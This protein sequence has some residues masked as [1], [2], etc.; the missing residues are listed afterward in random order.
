MR[1][2]ESSSAS[3]SPRIDVPL[4]GGS[5]S[6]LAEQA[7]DGDGYPLCPRCG[8]G[9]APG[10]SVVLEDRLMTHLTCDPGSGGPA[11]PVEVDPTIR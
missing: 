5:D 7:R 11:G 2:V 10:R 1:D 9:I 8:T 3:R 6:P 4:W